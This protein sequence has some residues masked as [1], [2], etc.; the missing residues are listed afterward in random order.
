[1][2]IRDSAQLTGPSS[3]DYG[4][5]DFRAGTTHETSVI[6]YGRF[7]DELGWEFAGEGRRRQDMIRFGVYNTRSF[8]SRQG[9][10]GGGE[11]YKNIGPIPLSVLN[12]NTNIKQNPG[13]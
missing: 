13:Y 3:Y 2:C 10:M 9:N 4:L 8:L 1:M 12:T 11:D 5:R 7:L 6:P